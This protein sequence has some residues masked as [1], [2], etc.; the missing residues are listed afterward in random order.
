MTRQAS[1]RTFLVQSTAAVIGSSVLSPARLFGEWAPLLLTYQG[2]LTDPDGVPRNG[3]F[4]MS[5]RIVDASGAPLRR[6]V[7]SHAGV[8][9][10]NG[11]FTVQLG[12]VTPLPADI[13]SGPPADRFG[14]VRF[15]EVT[16]AGELLSPNLRITGTAFAIEGANGPTGPDGAE[17]AT[18]PKGATGAGATGAA[19]PTGAQGAPGAPGGA[20][21]QAGPGAAGAAGA[22]GDAGPTGAQGPIGETG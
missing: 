6:W 11:F 2:R 16:V 17:G 8:K 7:E 9:V 12:S 3:T 18:G 14:A 15:L 19:G 4:P 5:F 13:F 10:Q 22:N 1:R 21:V 20:G